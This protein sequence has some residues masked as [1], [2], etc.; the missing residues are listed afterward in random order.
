VFPVSRKKNKRGKR[1]KPPNAPGPPQPIAL[2]PSAPESKTDLYGLLVGVLSGFF[3][4][5]VFVP[6]NAFILY[7]AWACPAV[8]LFLSVYKFS[9]WSRLV[10]GAVIVIGLAI[11]AVLAFYQTQDRL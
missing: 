1:D 9:R 2:P 3:L 10:N 7:V 4:A 8:V 11:L 5:V 6:D